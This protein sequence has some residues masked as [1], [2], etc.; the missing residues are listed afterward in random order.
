MVV[1]Q[2]SET[3]MLFVDR[4]FLSRV[5]AVPLAAA[6]SGGLTS[7]MLS[8]FF[9]G[10]VGY[11]NAIVAQYYGAGRRPMCARTTSQAVYLALACYPVLFA[12]TPVARL[13]FVAA[14]QG[15]EQIE[16]ATEY[17]RILISGSILLVGQFAL[18]SFFVGIG[19]TRIVMAANLLA[20]IVNVPCN[21]LLI[22][23]KAGFPA[24]GISGAA[25][26]TLCGRFASLVLLVVA[27]IRTCSQAGFS[28]SGQ[29]QF[30]PHIMRRLLKFGIPAGS[31]IFLSVSAFNIFV[32]LMH[33]YGPN[34]AAAVTIAF[35][36][37]IVAFIPVLG[38]GTATTALVGQYI[39]G[40][41]YESAV[42]STYLALKMAYIY[43]GSMMV[44]FLAG[45]ERLAHVFS[46]GFDTTGVVLQLSSTLLRLAALYTLADA[47]QLVFTGAL[48]GAGDTQWVMRVSIGLHWLLAVSALV[49][50]RVVHA[51]PV[52]VWCVFIGLIVSLGITM[53]VRFRRGAWKEIKLI[54]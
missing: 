39:G 17:L 54:E 49:L 19:R 25:L 33:S 48:R 50:I 15:A 3:V 13:I 35:N 43:A 2:A 41:D 16:L 21:Y 31:E 7:F 44:L 26:G 53:Y 47:T 30:R 42:A 38:I 45:A 18:V 14:G 46:S 1:S 12:M 22:F 27:Y 20:M 10:V 4:L 52:L 24:L 8:S 32:Q 9:T 36:W 6:M 29:W 40:K 34:V 28:H 51:A 23:G 5:G 37:D 11:S